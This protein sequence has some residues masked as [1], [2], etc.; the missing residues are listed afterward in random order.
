[1]LPQHVEM[2]LECSSSWIEEQ[3]GNVSEKLGQ[4]R[5]LVWTRFVSANAFEQAV[6]E[7]LVALDAIYGEDMEAIGATK[8]SV[9]RV[10]GPLVFWDAWFV[11]FM[12]N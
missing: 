9:V 5:I 6:M 11:T 8:Q 1:M 7:E 2:S 3:A 10:R 12:G 4:V